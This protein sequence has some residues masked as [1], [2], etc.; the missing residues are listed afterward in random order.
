MEQLAEAFRYQESGRHF[1]KVV[2]DI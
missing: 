1:G 2:V